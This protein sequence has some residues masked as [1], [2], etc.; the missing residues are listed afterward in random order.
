MLAPLRSNRPRCASS[1][2]LTSLPPT[3]HHTPAVMSSIVGKIFSLSFAQQNVPQL[4]GRKYIV[5]GG[6]STS[7]LTSP[8]SRTAS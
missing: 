5:T 6:P 4:V 2:W 7:S 8:S 1:L 3:T